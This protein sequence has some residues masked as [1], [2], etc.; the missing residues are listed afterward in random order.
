MFRV[1]RPLSIP[2]E[3]AKTAVA[4]SKLV[5]LANL[6]EDLREDLHK[7]AAARAALGVNDDGAGVFR[8]YCLVI[9]EQGFRTRACEFV[10]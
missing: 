6:D 4:G 9:G 7:A 10:A 5:C 2:D 8:E 1:Q 3:E